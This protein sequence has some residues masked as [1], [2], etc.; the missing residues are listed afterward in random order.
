MYLLKGSG[1]F[2]SVCLPS[3]AS[4]CSLKISSLGSPSPHAQFV[5]KVGISKNPICLVESNVFSFLLTLCATPYALFSAEDFL[6]ISYWILA[7]IF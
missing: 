7:E 1:Q 6:L 3:A 4:L 5:E 2:L